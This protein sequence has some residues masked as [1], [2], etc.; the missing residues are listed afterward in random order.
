MGKCIVSEE[1]E[2]L[3]H[4]LFGLDLQSVVFIVGVIPII[5]GVDCAARRRR[6]TSGGVS[7]TGVG[8][9]RNA[10]EEQTTAISRSLCGMK[11]CQ[12]TVSQRV[13]GHKVATRPDRHLVVVIGWSVAGKDVGSLVSDVSDSKIQ[14]RSKL[15]LK[16]D[17]PLVNG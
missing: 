1:L 15:A 3:A 8:E 16:R 10:V 4:A 14:G 11:S 17:I 7:E 5:A 6:Q 13:A 2:A 12:I 9:S